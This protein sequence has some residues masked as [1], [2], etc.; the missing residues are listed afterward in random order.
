MKF[1]LSSSNNTAL[2]GANEC[3]SW[4][5]VLLCFMSLFYLAFC[6]FYKLNKIVAIIGYVWS[7]IVAVSSIIVVAMHTCIFTIICT[8]FAGLMIFAI[9]Y[10]VI[11]K[12]LPIEKLIKRV[13][14]EKKIKKPQDDFVREDQNDDVIEVAVKDEEFENLSVDESDLQEDNLD[15][16]LAENLEQFIT[17]KEQEVPDAYVLDAVSGLPIQDAFTSEVKVEPEIVAEDIIPE[18]PVSEMKEVEQVE[19]GL[20]TPE[21]PLP[22]VEVFKQEESATTTEAV[23]QNPNQVKGREVVVH[24]VKNKFTDIV[25]SQIEG[26]PEMEETNT[27]SREELIKELENR[28]VM[29]KY[30]QVNFNSEAQPKTKAKKTKSKQEE[31]PVEEVQKI[32][33]GYQINKI[34]MD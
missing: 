12:K 22:K 8:F 17:P 28:P 11:T 29:V 16:L 18:T 27:K 33:R 3:L 24:P 23:N 4:V 14:E 26:M 1:L 20:K 34:I 32:N 10:V 25:V 21:I 5:L 6:M 19:I 2:C 9:L 15:K 30:Q 7:V 13:V 31:K